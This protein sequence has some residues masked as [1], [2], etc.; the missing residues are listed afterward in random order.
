MNQKFSM[1]LESSVKLAMSVL[2]G[3]LVIAVVVVGVAACAPKDEKL[4]GGTGS[5]QQQGE[6]DLP[7]GFPERND[8]TADYTAAMLFEVAEVAREIE[9]VAQAVEALNTPPAAVALVAVAPAALVTPTCVKTTTLNGPL[10]TLKFLNLYEDCKE[11]GADFEATQKGSESVFAALAGADGAKRAV[12]VRVESHG[13]PKQM[14]PL[15]NKK[16]S[17]S[18][19]QFR[20]LDADLVAE[21]A[22]ILTYKVSYGS[23]SAFQLDL[24]P[25]TDT[26]GLLSKIS[27]YVDFDLASRRVVR[28]WTDETVGLVSIAVLSGR[29]PRGGRNKLRQEFY[30]SAKPGQLALDLSRCVAPAGEFKTRFSIKSFGRDVQV[31]TEGGKKYFF[32]R[33]SDVKTA[34]N[35]I[36]ILAGNTPVKVS[37]C[38]KDGVFPI[39]EGMAGL[40]Y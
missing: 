27:G 25:Y 3:A 30:A 8:R 33:E 39:S 14:V 28:F 24:K 23:D 10:G 32:D 18:L 1:M 22:G 2:V 7:S 29:T 26:G 36:G 17:L 37:V 12:V 35:G 5:N 4:S 34:A 38:T 20:F 31:A 19:K 40:L 16:D 11:T 6:Q 15:K 9:T 13:L 21:N